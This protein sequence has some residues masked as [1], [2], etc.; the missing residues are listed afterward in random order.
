MMDILYN[1]FIFPVE[2][3]IG[4]S[5]IFSLRVFHDPALSIFGISL[6]ISVLTL[7]LYFRAEKYQH[8][9][10]DLKKRLQPVIDN[11]KSVFSG[12]ER[13]MRISIYYRQNGYH[14]IYALRSSLSLF[15]QIPFFIAAYHYLANLELIKNVPF[16]PIVDLA[17]PDSLFT[18]SG[19]TINILP[20]VM[21][22][23]NC[24]STAVYT[25]NFPVKDKI[26]LYGMAAIFL[27]LLYHSPSGMVLYWTGN[28]IFS[29]CKNIIQKTKYPKRIVHVLVSIACFIL[30]FFVLFL[31]KGEILRRI[32]LSVLL[33]CIPLFPFVFKILS[34]K[35]KQIF[36]RRENNYYTDSI[37]ILS[38]L[39]I[40]LLG[41]LVIPSSLIASSVQ[42][43]SF[44]ENN[45]SPYP[46]IANTALQSLGV[47]ILWPLLIYL[48]FSQNIKRKMAK[49]SIS[50]AGMA[51]VNVFLFQG[52]YG[53]LTN[54]F[55]FSKIVQSTTT[56]NLLN[57]FLIVLIATLFLLFMDKF[58]KVLVSGLV[59]AIF[60]FI[61]S[62]AMNFMNINRE[63][64]NFQQI[65]ENSIVTD[66]TDITDKPTYRFSKN[67]KNVLLIM[68]DRA[69]NGY[70]PY[71]F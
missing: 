59:I 20:V 45:K 48:M 36:R 30:I 14:P 50:L 18:I 64:H 70:L 15:I 2:Q 62:G 54:M 24:F 40:F 17:K 3:L 65:I 33:T 31:H 58:R 51:I 10:Q 9:E 21:T 57:L 29:L 27:L 1:V 25:K 47:C 38:L 22:L 11:I 5:Y 34:A 63:F 71:I 12:N 69:I 42:E 32:F 60:A 19:F 37:F 55:I 46:F 7:P 4:L 52:D 44:I 49:I 26:Q 16:G 68:L 53:F 43:F 28:N 61:L 8:S 56:I 13:F 23:I 39:T 41:G 66:T 67:G 6:A 35:I